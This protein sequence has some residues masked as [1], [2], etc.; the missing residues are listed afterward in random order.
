MLARGTLGSAG[1]WVGEVDS[2]TAHLEPNL[3]LVPRFSWS[4]SRGQVNTM[5]SKR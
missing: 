5:P 2:C 3:S 4:S 1:R